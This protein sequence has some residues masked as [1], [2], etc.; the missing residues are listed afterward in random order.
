MPHKGESPSFFLLHFYCNIPAGL[1]LPSFLPILRWSPP[2]LQRRESWA[3]E[4]STQEP[5]L[6]TSSESPRRRATAGERERCRAR[7]GRPAQPQRQRG[8]SSQEEPR[9]RAQQ[10]PRLPAPA[11]SN[12]PGQRERTKRLWGPQARERLQRPAAAGRFVQPRAQRARR[13]RAC[14]AIAEGAGSPRHRPAGFVRR[15]AR[16]RKSRLALERRG[17]P[18]P[19]PARAESVGKAATRWRQRERTSER[20][21]GR[22]PSGQGGRTRS[23]RELGAEQEDCPLPSSS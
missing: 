14:G 18:R 20:E 12:A 5:K 4:V 23:P 8:L 6:S 19:P 3:G 15:S 11:S 10:Q 22:K 13:E 16:A 17:A 1:P 21:P 7:G 9:L 2:P